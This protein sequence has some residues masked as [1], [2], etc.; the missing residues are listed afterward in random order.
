MSRRGI[1]ARSVVLRRPSKAIVDEFVSAINRAF[2]MP[3]LNKLKIRL[4]ANEILRLLKPSLSYKILN[5]LTG[6]PESV[7]CRYVRGNIVPSYEQ[8]VK[9]L[10]KVLLSI[11][12]DYLLR[13]LVEEERSNIIDLSRVLKDPYVIRLLTII[14]SLKLSN[15]NITKII[16]TAESVM[17]LATMVGIEM[18]V[19][20]ILV[21]K[22]A[23]PGIQYYSG[24]VTRSPKDIETLYIDRDLVNR[25]DNMLVLADVV[26]TGR[27]LETILTMLEKA[28][29]RVESIIVVLALGELW[30]NRLKGYSSKIEVLTHLP[31]PLV[32]ASF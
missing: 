4:L 24:V 20:I 30:R 26:Y 29:T 19:P 25:R 18:N 31:Y 6:V 2:S 10:A 21:K 15:K 28:R 22:K 23:Y 9:I 11:D 14:I 5:E 3:K 32:G 7:L 17:P 27:T 16:A 8:A 1:K 12:L 13:K